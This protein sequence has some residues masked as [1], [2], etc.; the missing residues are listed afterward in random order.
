MSNFGVIKRKYRRND[1][2]K[3]RLILTLLRLLILMLN[4]MWYINGRN[5]VKCDTLEQICF[6]I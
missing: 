5:W 1:K 6:I 4:E 3:V 2:D